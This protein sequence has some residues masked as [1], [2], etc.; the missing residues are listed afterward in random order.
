MPTK[1]RKK[2]VSQKEQL[3]RKKQSSAGYT[4]VPALTRAKAE[5]KKMEKNKDA[6]VKS[7]TEQVLKQMFG[8]MDKAAFEKF[9]KW[10][11][12]NE[13][14]FD[15]P[16]PKKRNTER[17]QYDNDPETGDLIITDKNGSTFRFITTPEGKTKI[18]VFIKFDK[19]Q[20][21]VQLIP[22]TNITQPAE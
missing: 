14:K 13:G 6:F 10:L 21:P 4:S 16:N 5:L 7:T 1:K 15:I 11:M 17:Y 18:K 9:T 20:E 12:A 8:K 19:D 2:A 22:E 3:R